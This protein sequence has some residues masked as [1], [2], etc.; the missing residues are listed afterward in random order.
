[1]TDQ[2]QI[3]ISDSIHNILK[4]LGENLDRPGLIKTPTRAASALQDLTS[5]YR[6]SPTDILNNALFPCDSQGLVVQKDLEFYSL[7]EHHLLPF[8]G[9]IH[10]AYTPNKNIIGLS[11]IGRLIDIFSRRLQVQESLTHQITHAINN[12]VKPHGVAVIIEASHL[13]M[14]MRGVKK[15]NSLTLTSEYLGNLSTDPMLRSEFQAMIK[16]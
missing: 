11:K 16:N 5:G 6:M 8:F 4:L 15:Q 14:M 12:I 7:C 9:R 13:C 2:N 1:M 10:V 3:Q